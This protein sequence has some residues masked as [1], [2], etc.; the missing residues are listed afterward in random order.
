MEKSKRNTEIN[1]KKQILAFLLP[2]FFKRQ[3]N[4]KKIAGE[5]KNKS[6]ASEKGTRFEIRRRVFLKN[7]PRLKLNAFRMLALRIDKTKATSKKDAKSKEIQRKRRL[8]LFFI[9]SPGY[10]F[11]YYTTRRDEKS[12]FCI[13]LFTRNEQDN[14]RNYCY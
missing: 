9:L 1:L 11:S 2:A 5:R 14:S 8:I 7:A 3:I 13:L 10:R 12:Q 6:S 4:P